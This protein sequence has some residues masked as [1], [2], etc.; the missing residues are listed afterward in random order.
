MRLRVST[1]SIGLAEGERASIERRVRQALGRHGSRIAAAEVSLQPSPRMHGPG[2][3]CCRIRVRLRDGRSWITEE[4]APG[5]REA[6]L[7]ASA[8]AE[9]RLDRER[10]LLQEGRSP[11]IRPPGDRPLSPCAARGHSGG[12]EPYTRPP[13]R[14]PRSDAAQRRE[15]IEACRTPFRRS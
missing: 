14:D 8:R 10:S 5:A 12:A 4:H 11:S 15:A 2:R 7:G 3:V 9:G 13:P 6:T 1:R